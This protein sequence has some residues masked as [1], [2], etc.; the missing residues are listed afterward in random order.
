[1]VTEKTPSFRYYRLQTRLKREVG[2]DDRSAE[3]LQSL[4]E[5]HERTP[6]FWLPREGHRPWPEFNVQPSE[7][8]GVLLAD[9]P[10]QWHAQ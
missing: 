3:A 10:P 4:T 9:R 6:D 7:L 8:V 2:L 5:H 1:M